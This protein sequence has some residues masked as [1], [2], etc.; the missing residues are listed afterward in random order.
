MVV[1]YEDLATRQRAT[2]VCDDLVKKFWPE[3]CFKFDWWRVNFL[4][5]KGFAELAAGTAE[6]SELVIFSGTEHRE[7]SIATKRWFEKWARSRGRREGALV[8]LTETANSV[9]GVAELK[10]IY[11]RDIASRAFMDYVTKVPGDL[12]TA[13]RS[14]S[15]PPKHDRIESVPGLRNVARSFPDRSIHHISR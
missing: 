2:A 15:E 4:E 11:L 9:N 8:D 13:L 12:R 3:I 1:V 14:R 5:D 7:L 6:S 10:K